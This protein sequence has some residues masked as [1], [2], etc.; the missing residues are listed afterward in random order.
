M[1]V[2]LD[3]Q[4]RRCADNRSLWL[5]LVASNDHPSLPAEPASVPLTPH[6]T[7]AASLL[8]HAPKPSPDTVPD[9]HNGPM[10]TLTFNCVAD[11]L[12]WLSR[13]RD[14]RLLTEGDA[15]VSIQGLPECL[16]SADH[17]QVL[18]V[19]SLHLVG[20]ILG[21]LDPLVCDK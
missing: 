11:G 20:D 3:G 4:L 18:C 13:G 16:K 2:T 14:S 8:Q 10:P 19:G 5:D 6:L 15:P 9:P 7:T 12:I 1:K 17:I 21:M